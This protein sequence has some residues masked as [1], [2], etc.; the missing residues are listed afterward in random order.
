MQADWEVEIG[1]DA[2]DIEGVWPGF[3]D[4]RIVPEQIF[5]VSEV[6]ALPALGKILVRLNAR[7][8]PVWT[9]K[10]DVWAVEC[11]AEVHLDAFDLDA[12]GDEIAYVQACYIDLLPHTDRPWQLLERAELAAKILCSR[13]QSVPLRCC[14]ADLVVR[15]AWVAPGTCD[16]GITAYLTACGRDELS[17]R[18]TLA[19]ALHAF[20]D[21]VL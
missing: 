10:C 8:S 2:P 13:L 12:D 5:K 16:F 14:R 21:A 11:L 18:A 6:L 4:L 17:A 7:T 20:A 3:V 1:G 9:S 19:A 15:R